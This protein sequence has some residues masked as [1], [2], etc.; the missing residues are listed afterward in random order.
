MG[1]LGELTRD[2]S[3]VL[4]GVAVVLDALVAAHRV[5]RWAIRATSRKDPF[6]LNKQHVS[7]MAAVLEG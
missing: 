6:S 5:E 1:G 7:H 3:R 4:V 2:S